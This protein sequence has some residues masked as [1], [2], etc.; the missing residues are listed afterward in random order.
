MRPGSQVGYRVDVV[1]SKVF[2]VVV[3]DLLH[4][5]AVDRNIGDAEIRS[6]LANPGYSGAGKADLDGSAQESPP[7]TGQIAFIPGTIEDAPVGGAATAGRK[8][9][10][11][12]CG[13][14]HSAT[15]WR[16]CTLGRIGHRRKLPRRRF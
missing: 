10:R 11:W 5:F 6:L 13:A 16:R 12:V 9:N 2:G 15:G 8:D 14:D 4:S 7:G 1:E 3:V